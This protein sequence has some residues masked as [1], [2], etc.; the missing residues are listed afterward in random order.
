MLHKDALGEGAILASLG[1]L[2][3]DAL[4]NGIGWATIL[5][6]LPG[7]P[8]ITANVVQHQ[9]ANL[10]ASGDYARILSAVQAEIEQEHAAQLAALAALI[11]RL[12]RRRA[13]SDM[14]FGEFRR[15]LTY[16][17]A[18][19]GTTIVVADRFFPSSKLCS[20][21]GCLNETLTLKDRVYHCAECGLMLDRD[22]NAARN[23]QHIAETTAS[24]AGRY[25]CGVVSAGVR[26]WE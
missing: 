16:K 13:I 4:K 19:S 1:I 3:D 5:K 22:V 23:L 15:Q 21:C 7:I 12:A 11:A 26:S 25:A 9:L 20:Q 6:L 10:H 8:G 24:S 14:G 18:L 2:K 17:A